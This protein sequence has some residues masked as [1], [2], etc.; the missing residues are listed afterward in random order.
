[1]LKR[2]SSGKYEYT[3][4]ERE[5]LNV[6]IGEQQI[7]K[8]IIKVLKK[9]KY[10][11]QL[12]ELRKHRATNDDLKYDNVKIEGKRLPVFK[13]IDLIVKRAQLKAEQQLMVEYPEI[14]SNVQDQKVIDGYMEQGKIDEAKGIAEENQD[15]VELLQMAK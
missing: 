14:L 1:M 7:Y 4:H 2:H 10:Q 15:M 9:P 3:A 8:D 13:E 12:A 6:L 5:R 11:D